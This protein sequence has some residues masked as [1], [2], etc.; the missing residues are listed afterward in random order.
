MSAITIFD[1][2]SKA[3]RQMVKDLQPVLTERGKIKIGMKGR[4]IT[5]RAGNVFQPPQKLDHF[6]IT[7]LSRAADNNFVRDE[8]IHKALG[9]KPTRIPIRLIFNEIDL[10]FQTRYVA[11]Q[12]RTIWCQGDG[13]IAVREGK[14]RQCP[15]P[16]RERGYDEKRDRQGP[17]CKIN[18]RL[19]VMIDGA[20]G[21]GGVWVMRTTSWNTVQGLISSMALIASIT[22]GRL[23]GV[24]LSL[25]VSPKQATD[26]SGKQVTVYVVGIEY[27]GSVDDL[28]ERAYNA[29]LA[30]AAQGERLAHIQEA[31]RR[32]ISAPVV[33]PDEETDVA[34]EFYP[35]AVEAVIAKGEPM[36][37]SHNRR[38]AMREPEPAATI[39]LTDANGD[40]SFVMPAE[41]DAWIAARIEEAAGDRE[42]LAELAAANPGYADLFQ[43]GTSGPDPYEIADEAGEVIATELT[44]KDALTSYGRVKAAANDKRAVA[45]AN[46]DVLRRIADSGEIGNRT[47]SKL[48]AEIEAAE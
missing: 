33:S 19:Q 25:T 41:V 36:A 38:A 22:G 34:E 37:P 7:T 4:E 10:N 9:D 17:V 16:N 14:D 5:S 32:L 45:V 29:A 30:D 21:V 6:L 18:G 27:V 12:G 39:E 26:P 2:V 44:A 13:E 15:C 20:A 48:R 47:L 35:D 46:L 1:R 23:A 24:P 43:D 28:R 3:P 8:T 31:A 40:S 42:T 11:F